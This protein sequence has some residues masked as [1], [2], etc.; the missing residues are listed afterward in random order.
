[1]LR[2]I[3]LLLAAAPACASCPT[4][5]DA[6]GQSWPGTCFV[7][8]LGNDTTGTGTWA[9][10]FLTIG[11]AYTTMGTGTGDSIVIRGGRYGGDGNTI[12]QP[13]TAKCSAAL[14]CTIRSYPGEVVI[15]D[16][17]AMSYRAW[18]MSKFGALTDTPMF[19]SD[20][21][22]GHWRIVGLRFENVPG[23][24]V[25][26][27]G[28]TD[29]M[30]LKSVRSHGP[31]GLA[32][33]TC[34]SCRIFGSHIEV[35]GPTI[36]KGLEGAAFGC[37][38]LFPTYYQSPWTSDSTTGYQTTYWQIVNQAP[39]VVNGIYPSGCNDLLVQDSEF[40]KRH[41]TAVDTFGFETANGV[42]LERFRARS[43]MHQGTDVLWT[44]W[45]TQAGT[46]GIDIK[47]RNILIKD[48]SSIG[49]KG[50]LK[51]WGSATVE[52]TLV[53]GGDDT[54][55]GA[56]S[57]MQRYYQATST[58]DWPN[59]V[60]YKTVRDVFNDPY[61]GDAI[62]VMS[63]I[64]GGMG[65]IEGTE[66]II[67]GVPGCTGI[68]GNKVIKHIYHGNG[69]PVMFSVQN[70]DGS[71][72]TCPDAYTIAAHNF[73]V[74]PT[75]G[76]WFTPVTFTNGSQDVTV[77]GLTS[78]YLVYAYDRIRFTTDGT[79]PAEISAGTDY[80]I[81]YK[82]STTVRLSATR[83]G[84]AI[85]FSGPGTGTHG[86]QIIDERTSY[87]GTVMIAPYTQT[88]RNMSILSKYRFAVDL[89][90]TCDDRIG[91]SI[92]WTA[93]NNVV[94]SP[95]TGAVKEAFFIVARPRAFFTNGAPDV[96]LEYFDTAALVVGHAVYFTS[97]CTLPTPLQPRTAYY[98]VA[99]DSGAG[100]IQI[101]TSPGGTAISNYV[102][103]AGC[104]YARH[105][106]TADNFTSSVVSVSA[107][108]F[109]PGDT[110]TV[111][112][113]RTPPYPLADGGTYY[114]DT[115]AAAT[116][117]GVTFRHLTLKNSAGDPSPISFSAPSNRL[118]S[119]L[120][121]VAAPGSALRNWE[122][123]SYTTLVA[124]GNNLYYAPDA[125]KA[126][127][128]MNKAHGGVDTQGS[129]ALN[130][131]GL[132]A[133]EPT[134]VIAD[135]AV[136]YSTGRAT[137]GSPA[138][139]T[140]KGALAGTNSVALASASKQVLRFRAPAATDTCSIVVSANPDFSSPVESLS[141]SPG[142]IWRFQV[143]G[144]STPLASN[145]TYY[146]QI[147]CGY[148]VFTG[149]GA[150]GLAPS[151]SGAVSVS[152]AAGQATET[153]AALDYSTDGSAWTSGTPAA[154]SSGCT[155]SATLTHG[156]LYWLRTRRVSAGGTTLST[157]AAGYAVP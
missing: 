3:V 102:N 157:S 73:K 136:D 28:V 125:V 130:E 74:Q 60:E 93:E 113:Y 112:G 15:I 42:T 148:D 151:G 121:L 127:C 128:G 129:C 17:A 50:A 142:A 23:G 31:T 7:S 90:G 10:P 6:A 118:D 124:A 97:T 79:L 51:V 2:W 9:A 82:N 48:S 107:D 150:T 35:D 16:G 99:A 120:R 117:G 53:V 19:S 153:Q 29:D 49:G 64:I 85:T 5:N 55:E 61:N 109:S 40:I 154:C 111:G 119:T 46:D 45:G 137:A 34:G 145:T 54:G 11:K 103:N 108:V 110:V 59:S 58:A 84:T 139:L 89:C 140:N 141:S 39:A 75:A 104:V 80:W 13:A 115:S 123:S 68:N 12:Y 91:T 70:T 37:S 92:G 57:G 62:V 66:V 67:A 152:L 156:A 105:F 22:D 149:V 38:G 143:L 76:T 131:A 43:P 24:P 69:Y 106:L 56:L 52:N 27:Q 96:T 20:P 4:S 36:Q 144:A 83:G 94:S 114:V 133:Q 21:R 81:T 26:D 98:V 25:W 32:F 126:F 14:P 8:A 135:P 86:A 122:V 100:T 41:S 87:A 155:L 88:F 44:L 63:K 47:G 116:V 78:S 147:T 132:Q 18:Y 65:A 1:M 101:A 134:S 146:H 71:A 95:N 30:V 138:T 33:S 77:T 72:L